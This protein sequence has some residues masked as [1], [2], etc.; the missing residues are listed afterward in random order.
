MTDVPASLFDLGPVARRDALRLLAQTE[1][2]VAMPEGAWILHW[3]DVRALLRDRRLA[4]VGLVVFDALG[5]PW[6][7][8][9]SVASSMRGE[10]RSTN[11]LDLVADL[12]T[13]HVAPLVWTLR[14][15]IEGRECANLDRLVIPF[16]IRA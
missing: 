5:V 13:E 16:T 14:D 9:G 10:P 2:T 15:V 6:L 7:I 4:G 8:G 11:D 1:R 3:E 12:R